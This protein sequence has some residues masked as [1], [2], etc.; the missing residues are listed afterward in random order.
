MNRNSN[1]TIRTVSI[2]GLGIAL[3]IV[4]AFIALNLRLPIYLDSVG[5]ILIAFLLGP[6]A[7]II[8]GLSGS[9]I[10]STFDIY[11]LYF[12][13]VQILTGFLSGYFYKKNLVSA[14]TIPI[15]G[16]LVAIPVSL[17]GSVI[18]A[19]L[20]GGVTSSGSSYIVQILSTIGVNKVV[21]I[22]ITQIFTDYFDKIAAMYIAVLALSYL[23]K[24]LLAKFKK[25]N[26]N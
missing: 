12:A 7:A 2:M 17:L 24:E 6:R 20:F 10:S 22:F 25:I 15:V 14:K 21:A 26:Y 5:T 13:P 16:I 19:F 4:G 8:T 3:N 18:A 11:S 23:P 1:K 9:I